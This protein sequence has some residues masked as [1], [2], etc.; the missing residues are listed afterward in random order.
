ML[1]PFLSAV[2]ALLGGGALAQVEDGV[3]VVNG[4]EYAIVRLVTSPPGLG[5]WTDNLLPPPPL[6][7]GEA[8][9]LKVAPF[10][11][12]CLQDVRVTFE[13]GAQEAEWKRVRLCDVRKLGLFLDRDSGRAFVTYE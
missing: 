1:R 7:A 9:K 11:G 13:S 12:Q 4:T 8:R 6:K 3:L 10:G 5:F 2:F